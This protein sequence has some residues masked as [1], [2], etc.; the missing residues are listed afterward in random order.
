ME[1]PLYTKPH[2]SFNFVAVFAI[3]LNISYFITYILNTVT[4]MVI[5]AHLCFN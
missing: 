3:L 2:L 5:S 1:P 4:L